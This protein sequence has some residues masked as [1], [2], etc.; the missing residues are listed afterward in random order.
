MRCSLPFPVCSALVL[1]RALR[2]QGVS[3]KQRAPCS[4]GPDRSEAPE[5]LE[6]LSWLDVR[7]SIKDAALFAI[8]KLIASVAESS[9]DPFMKATLWF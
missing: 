6:T 5:A 9:A 1:A 2:V 4:Q 3:L 8:L 7:G